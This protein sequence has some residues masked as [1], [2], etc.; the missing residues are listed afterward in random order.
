[1][2]FRS[3]LRSEP[4]WVVIGLFWL[5]MGGIYL[6]HLITGWTPNREALNLA[7]L[8][9]FA[10]YWYGVV[11][12]AGVTLGSYVASK[13]AHE[14]AV[15]LLEQTVPAKIRRRSVDEL[16]LPAEIKAILTKNRITTWG[17]LLLVWGF[18]PEA[19]GLNRIGVRAVR[20][21]LAAAADLDPLWISD[22]PPWR[23]WNPDY[24]WG[25]IGVCLVLG[26]IGARLY[27]VLTPSPSMAAVGINSPLDYFRNPWQLINLRNGGLGIYGGILGGV[28]GLL[29]YT[30]RHRLSTLVWADLA[31]IG[32]SL[33]QMMGR[34]GNFFNQE[35]Y[36]RPTTLPW[37]VRID[38]TNRLAA[39]ADVERF[40]P[41][42]L[43]ESL[44]S[45]LTFVVLHTLAKRYQDKVQ[46]GELTALYLIFYG[47][48]RTLLELVRLDSRTVSLG[49]V[50]LNLPIATLVSLVIA[51]L[52]AIWVGLRRR[53]ARFKT[54]S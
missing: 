8:G 43:Y 40:H 29:W 9:D 15:A 25:G 23:Q 27:H 3:I 11:I 24:V 19:M 12:M 53:N 42:F 36:G 30:R 52:M 6:N 50:D 4:Y 14:R 44:W 46:P 17:Q 16:G 2:K 47:V 7:F 22:D 31:A 21:K 39:Y 37:A 45:L 38:P 13:M 51:L 28:L 48:G 35:L 10:V 33:G 49:G 54:N 18:N 1:M 41:A 20:E 34:W 26:V 32:L 5:I